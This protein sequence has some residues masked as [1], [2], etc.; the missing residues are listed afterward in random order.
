[1]LPLVDLQGVAGG[2]T[3]GFAEATDFHF[4]CQSE[5]RT[6]GV[7][8]KRETRVRSGKRRRRRRNRRGNGSGDRWAHRRWNH[9]VRSSACPD[10]T[11]EKSPEQGC[12][13]L[14]RNRPT[15]GPEP[16]IRSASK[17]HVRI[18][19]QVLLGKEKLTL[20]KAFRQSTHRNLVARLNLSHGRG[21]FT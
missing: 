5:N 11:E 18:D 20:L 4:A 8:W 19:R 17:D 14:I 6:G 7:D 12:H 21:R 3:K 15:K 9:R 1:M 10:L 16:A 13:P 2:I